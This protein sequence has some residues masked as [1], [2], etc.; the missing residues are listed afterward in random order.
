MKLLL[1]AFSFFII[2]KCPGLCFKR[3]QWRLIALMLHHVTGQICPK[4]HIK[5]IYVISESAAMGRNDICF[6]SHGRPFLPP[7]SA[8]PPKPHLIKPFRRARGATTVRCVRA[9]MLQDAARGRDGEQ[10]HAGGDGEALKKSVGGFSLWKRAPLLLS[11]C[12]LF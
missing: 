1:G 2:T 11:A 4:Q 7:V 3:P 9:A 12:M 8:D 6:W 10:S 5:R